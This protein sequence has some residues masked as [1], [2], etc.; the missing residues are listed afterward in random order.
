MEILWG[1]LQR[2]HLQSMIAHVRQ[3]RPARR[4]RMNV[5]ENPMQ[6]ARAVIQKHWRRTC[7]HAPHQVL[8]PFAFH[9][10]FQQVL[11]RLPGSPR[12][13]LPACNWRR[14]FADKRD[15]A[16]RPATTPWTIWIVECVG[17][18]HAHIRMRRVEGTVATNVA[19]N[20]SV[21]IVR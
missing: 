11:R 1:V 13:N 10:V 8:V 5:Q 21:R 18:V 12:C 19:H 4:R 2:Q 17:E 9:R 20:V 7:G 14:V 16:P 6:P 15:V 3:A